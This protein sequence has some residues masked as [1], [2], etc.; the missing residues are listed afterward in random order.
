MP[1]MLYDSTVATCLQLLPAIS[2]LI[3]KAEA[4]CRANN[5]PD[6]AL[7]EASLAPD[8]WPL[9][10]Q[11]QEVCLHSAGAVTGAM[12]G[13]WQRDTSPP[14][15]DFAQ[16]RGAVE[17][18]IAQ[19]QAISPAALEAVIGKDMV[20]VINAE[21][22]M[23]FTTENYLLSFAIPNFLFH[24]TTVYAILRAQGLAIGKRDFLGAV[25]IKA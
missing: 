7:L 9:T 10:R 14:G 24:V 12:A 4:H 2:K 22:Q 8:M 6:S 23:K 17:D 15:S 25:R 21:I 11:I 18:A 19:L 13:K 5:L 1:L 16:L 20:F 3:D